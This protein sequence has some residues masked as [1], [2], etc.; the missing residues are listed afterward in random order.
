MR[1]RLF[2]GIRPAGKRRLVIGGVLLTRRE[3]RGQAL[4]L[5]FEKLFQNEPIPD[6]ILL[7]VEAGRYD[8][9][10]FSEKLASGVFEHLEEID[11]VVEKYTIG[12]SK[13]RLA[14][15][16]LSILRLAIYEMTYEEDT[17]V[18]VAIN[19]AVELAK[20]FGGDGDAALINGVLG[21]YARGELHEESEKPAP[22]QDKNENENITE[23]S[24]E[25]KESKQSQENVRTESAAEENPDAGKNAGAEPGGEDNA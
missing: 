8:P 10:S 24:K 14:K 4:C 16:V 23:E 15:I 9:D 5:V 3:A 22:K 12:W 18:S 6:I 2:F 21:S 20:K 1:V 25:S 11:A 19:E 13:K 7:A 17:P